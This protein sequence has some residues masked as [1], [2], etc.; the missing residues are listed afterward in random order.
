MIEF[1]E[2]AYPVQVDFRESYSTGAEVFLV[3]PETPDEFSQAIVERASQRGE[4]V[5]MLQGT[6]F[7]VVIGENHRLDIGD[8]SNFSNLDDRFYG[9]QRAALPPMYRTG[10]VV[11]FLRIY[12]DA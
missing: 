12:L 9:D 8:L 7:P 4:R 2:L 3:F 11:H 6:R 5:R 10:D 1:N